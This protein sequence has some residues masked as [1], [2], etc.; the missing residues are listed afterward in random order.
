MSLL[1]Y[2]RITY[3]PT[4]RGNLRVRVEDDGAVFAQLNQRD[5]PVG[6]DWDAPW[7]AEPSRRLTDAPATLRRLLQQGG[8][9]ALA[10]V[11]RDDRRKDG[12]REV[13]AFHGDPP[14]TVT[15]DRATV[16]PF[17]QLVNSLLWELGVAE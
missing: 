14:H 16:P 10:P 5:P 3:H 17:Q 7:P 12:I 11:H 6:E 15:V 8:F 9:F 4:K 1:E 2:E 13:L